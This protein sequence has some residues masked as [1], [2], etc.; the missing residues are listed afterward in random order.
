MSRRSQSLPRFNLIFFS[1]TSASNFK[2]Y[3]NFYCFIR[4]GSLEIVG[5]MMDGNCVSRSEIRVVLS[6]IGFAS[7]NNPRS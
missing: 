4:G 7:E 2:D 6:R 5:H 1:H 3:E